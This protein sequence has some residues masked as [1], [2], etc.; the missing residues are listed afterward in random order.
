MGCCWSGPGPGT[1]A[2]LA[3]Q[4]LHLARTT[5]TSSNSSQARELRKLI[6][7]EMVEQERGYISSMDTLVSHFINP[8]VA[9]ETAVPRD[10]V[11]TPDSYAPYN[12]VQLLS[13]RCGVREIM[14][15]HYQFLQDLENSLAAWDQVFIIMFSNEL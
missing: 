2:L 8:M 6:M 7:R 9:M 3:S 10:L 13:M 4:T 5:L 11:M 12:F 15:V 14:E 1:V